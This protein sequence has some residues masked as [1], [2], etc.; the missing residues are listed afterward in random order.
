MQETGAPEQ[1]LKGYVKP[2]LKKHGELKQITFSTHDSEQ[3]TKTDTPTTAKPSSGG[4]TPIVR[5]V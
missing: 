4:G 1:A 5:N 3:P 2:T